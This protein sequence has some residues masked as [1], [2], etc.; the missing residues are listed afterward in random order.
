MRQEDGS[1]TNKWTRDA[2]SF[3]KC[4]RRSTGG[5]GVEDEEE[6]EE[7]DDDELEEDVEKAFGY[8]AEPSIH[9]N[10]IRSRD[11]LHQI[12]KKDGQSMVIKTNLR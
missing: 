4:G 2:L 6:D 9:S 11:A 5:G 8:L 12:D 7:E 1:R 3:F 10:N